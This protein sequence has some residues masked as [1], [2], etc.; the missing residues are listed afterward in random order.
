MNKVRIVLKSVSGKAELE[1]DGYAVVI[2][3]LPMV[4]HPTAETNADGCL[5][6]PPQCGWQVSEP[7]TGAKLSRGYPTRTKAIQY[8]AY[9]IAKFGGAAKV[10]GVI[11]STLA[12]QT[13]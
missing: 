10:M 3:G 12:T 7:K 2:D 5:W 11:S 1:V 6:T 8:A 13:V 4:V 9:R